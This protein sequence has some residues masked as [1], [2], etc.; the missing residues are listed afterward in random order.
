LRLPPATAIALVSGEGAPDLAGRLR[1]AGRE[2]G[3]EVQGPDGAGRFMVRG[4]D[5]DALCDALAATP[6]PT[7]RVRV[8]VDPRRA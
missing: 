2:R 6:R 7:G 5:H 4:P 8:E 1:Q 3:V